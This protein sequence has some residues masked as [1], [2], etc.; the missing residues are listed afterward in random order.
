MRAGLR[1]RSARALAQVGYLSLTDLEGL[2]RDELI[3]IPGVGLSTLAILEEILERPLGKDGRP[4]VQRSRPL[5]PEEVWR[6]RG[7]PSS[8]AITFAQIGMTLERLKSMSRGEL[9]R[10]PGVGP[11]AVRVCRWMTGRTSQGRH[12]R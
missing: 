12:G 10:L 2:V 6:K 9:L 3:S 1:P 8:A 5:W 7:L 11:G 4:M